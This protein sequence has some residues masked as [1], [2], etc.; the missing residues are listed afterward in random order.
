MRLGE[1]RQ[2][3]PGATWRTPPSRNGCDGTNRRPRNLLQPIPGA[4]GGVCERTWCDLAEY[5]SKLR[6]V[7]PI[8]AWRTPPSCTNPSFPRTVY[9]LFY[10]S[11]N[12]KPGI[13]LTPISL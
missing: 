11:G 13:L 5:A 12:S 9:V 7:A 8:P 4:L 3:T 6:Q 10:K 2:D 1:L